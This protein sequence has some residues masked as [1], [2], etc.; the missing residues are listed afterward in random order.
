MFILFAKRLVINASV[1][2]NFLTNAVLATMLLKNPSTLEVLEFNTLVQVAIMS[3][4]AVELCSL[5]LSSTHLMP[6]HL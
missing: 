1:A 2:S 4:N 5:D 3:E 6:F